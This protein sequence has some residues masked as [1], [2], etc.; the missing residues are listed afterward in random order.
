MGNEVF[1]HFNELGQVMKIKLTVGN[2]M[3]YEKCMVLHTIQK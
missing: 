2:K 3:N 1:L